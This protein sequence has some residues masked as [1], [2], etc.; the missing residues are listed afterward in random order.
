[1]SKSSRH[2]F[3]PPPTRSELLREKLLIR[4]AEQ[5]LHVAPDIA[6]RDSPAAL[7]EVSIPGAGE[8]KRRRARVSKRGGRLARFRFYGASHLA[9]R[10]SVSSSRPRRHLYTSWSCSLAEDAW[11]VNCVPSSSSRNADDCAVSEGSAEYLRFRRQGMADVCRGGLNEYSRRPSVGRGVR[12]RRVCARE[13]D[14][15]TA[16][17]R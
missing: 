14:C 10:S 11:K 17:Q 1:M 4:T 12:T 7:E 5:P 3:N 9:A 15:T 16:W 8:G 2:S 6:A 13:R